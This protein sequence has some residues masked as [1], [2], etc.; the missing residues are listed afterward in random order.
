MSEGEELSQSATSGAEEAATHIIPMSD[1]EEYVFNRCKM[2]NYKDMTYCDLLYT[3]EE[4]EE[5]DKCRERSL[6]E[7]A[8]MREKATKKLAAQFRGRRRRGGGGGAEEEAAK[9]RFPK[10]S[11]V[12][13][14]GSKRRRPKRMKRIPSRS[15]SKLSRSKLSKKKKSKK[16]RKKTRRRRR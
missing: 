2:H 3:K 11:T 8:A 6:L 4:Q 16:K 15:R 14:G 13:T 1:I 10:R 5:Y 9:S 7:Y 12:N